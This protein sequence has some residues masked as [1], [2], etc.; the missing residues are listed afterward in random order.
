MMVRR[1]AI[2]KAGMMAAHF[3]LYYEEM[4]WC[5]MIKRAGFTIRLN[6]QALIYHK[7]SVSVGKASALKEFYMNRN[8]ILFI[9]RNAPAF[10]KI[11][12]YGY[13]ISVVTPRNV[14][15]YI[16][17]KQYSFIPVLFKAIA[18]NITHSK[19]SM[20]PGYPISK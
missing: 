8:R 14:I 7:E 11:L 20:D 19:D 13:F 18:W 15:R 12:F 3:F 5:E 4:D 1:T 2:E 16:K 6:M 17:E 9:R 10:K